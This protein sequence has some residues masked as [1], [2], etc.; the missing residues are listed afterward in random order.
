M[1]ITTE[2]S[3]TTETREPQAINHHKSPKSHILLTVAAYAT[4]RA[5]ARP[6]WTRRSVRHRDCGLDRTSR[7]RRAR[8]RSSRS[9]AAR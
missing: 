1:S 2:T 5:P 7:M 6:A 8:R 4:V 3:T 9:S